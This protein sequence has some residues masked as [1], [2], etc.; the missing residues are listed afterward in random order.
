MN[1]R[2]RG[3]AGG[4]VGWR[5]R[6]PA[7]GRVGW[8]VRGPAG[9]RVG[10]RVRGPAGDPRTRRAA[11]EVL[12]ALAVASPL[13][14]RNDVVL[15]PFRALTGRRCPFCGL[16][17]SL[18]ALTRGRLRESVAAHPLGPV[19][20]LAAA[21]CLLAD[22]GAPATTTGVVSQNF[23]CSLASRLGATGAA[24]TAEG[25]GRTCAGR[26]GPG[27]PRRR[28]AAVKF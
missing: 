12:L 5:V 14:T 4:R 13:A 10:W 8:R 20:A 21:G 27:V 24:R 17:R 11:A 7:G 6:G 25:T 22:R 16:T 15:C 23:G 26:V 1:G 19:L 18:A 28:E 2:V 9:G 3:P